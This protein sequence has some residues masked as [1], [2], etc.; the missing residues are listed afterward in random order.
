VTDCVTIMADTAG[1]P[2]TRGDDRRRSSGS[3]GQLAMGPGLLRDE[4]AAG[5]NPATPTRISAGQRASFFLS[6]SRV[7]RWC[8]ILGAEWEP[9]LVGGSR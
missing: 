4:E 7:V 2:R 3:G 5:S 6:A 9:I 8:P 1:P